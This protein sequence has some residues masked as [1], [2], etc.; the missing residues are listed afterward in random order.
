MMQNS[1]ENNKG[2]RRQDTI[3]KINGEFIIRDFNGTIYAIA[4]GDGMQDFKGEVR[5]NATARLLWGKLA[6]SC[7]K[8]DLTD[9]LLENY[10]ID[11]ATAQADVDRFITAMKNAHLI[12]EQKE[13]G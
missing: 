4:S 10:E 3:L 1:T 2:A 12:I 7:T 11:R 13:I 6:E 8:D 9:C 5:L